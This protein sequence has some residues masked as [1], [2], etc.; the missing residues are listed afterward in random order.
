M[1][2]V[3]LLVA[4]CAPGPVA[5]PAASRGDD[6]ST[7]IG[8]APATSPPAEAARALERV[9]VGYATPTGAF[10]APWAAKEAGLC[11][12]YGLDC[13]LTYVASGP[14]LI[15]ATVAGELDFG[16]L[17]A[18]ASMHAYVEGADVVWITGAVNVPISFIIAA[19]EIMRV[20]DLRGRTVG[21]TRIGTTTHTFMNVALRAAG[22]DPERDVQVFQ[23]GGTP[24][25]R[26]ALASGRIAAAALGPSYLLLPQDGIHVVADVA[27]LGIPWPYGGAISTRRQIAERPERVRRYVQAYTAAVARLRADPELAI[28]V[29]MRYGEVADRAIA[30]QQWAMFVPHFTL[31]PYPQRAA[32]EAAVS[33]ELA[34]TSPRA[35]EIPPQEFYDDR[36]VRELD[37][38][39]FV[40]GLGGR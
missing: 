2:A 34:A 6:A 40:R 37:E 30:A 31:P 10:A 3:A 13:E 27:G 16:E 12:Q 21:V 35:L 5:G 26:G 14:T 4:A 9:R 24:E 17:A 19:P 28:A 20:E 32:M 23:T 1:L 29:L 8:G 39:G 33:E 36:F 22:L 15:Q 38:S 11:E 25:T 7:A 18:P